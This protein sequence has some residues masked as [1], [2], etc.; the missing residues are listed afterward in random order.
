[1]GNPDYIYISD[2]IV[3]KSSEKIVRIS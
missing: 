2:A 1:M 3:T